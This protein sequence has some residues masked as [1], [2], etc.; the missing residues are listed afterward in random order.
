MPGLTENGLEILTQPE[1]QAI[2]EAAVREAFPGIDLT[3]GPESQLIG[4]LS[5]QVA[6]VYEL[7]QAIYAAAYPD[8]ANG[9]LLDQVAALTGTT[10]RPATKS[11][12]TLTLT[13]DDGTTVPAGSIVAVSG[14]PDRQFATLV[15]VTNSSGLDG[16]P[17]DVVAEC[18]EM[19]PIAA[20]AGTLT[21]IVTPIGGWT[22]VT[23][24]SDAEKGLEPAKD[25]ELRTQRLV[26]LAG[27]GQ[28]SYAAIR[29]AVAELEG[30]QEVAVYGNETLI[31]D[32]AG[33]PGKSFEVVVWDGSVPG[34]DDDAIAQAIW[35]TKPAGI[36]P[37]GS[38][39]GTAIRDSG[40]EVAVAFTR[41]TSLRGRVAAT[42]VLGADVGP[43]WAA[44]AQQAI[45]DRVAQY[46]VGQT[47][48]AS[49]LVCA[50]LAVPGIVAV[51]SL[52]LDTA[53]PP[54][55]TSITTAY[56]EIIRVVLDDVTVTEA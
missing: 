46:R 23:N 50:L 56:N 1:L 53:A 9:I 25:P 11:R 40:E 31:T 30:V 27:A 19:G 12:V 17:I 28:D 37:Y 6:I 22:A 44:Q 8:S 47:G 20:P 39:S 2:L 54:V 7:L 21:V 32:A 35:N 42:V 26:E 14:Q 34:A 41:A 55:A 13:L 4:V 10:R 45:V 18:L 52:T 3:E 36:P 38:S 48:Y 51:P 43:S 16:Q 15:D 33:R 5:E 49:Q 29:A 24:S